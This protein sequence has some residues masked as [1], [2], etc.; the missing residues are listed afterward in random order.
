MFRVFNVP[1]QLLKAISKLYEYAKAMVIMLDGGTK[2][3][4]M[5]TR[6]LQSVT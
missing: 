1:R 5:I 6:V 2:Y 3:F 4:E